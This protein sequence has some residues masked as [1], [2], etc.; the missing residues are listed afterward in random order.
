[1]A[2]SADDDRHGIIGLTMIDCLYARSLLIWMRED[3]AKEDSVLGVGRLTP[4]A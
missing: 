3:S 4:G 1:M 2:P